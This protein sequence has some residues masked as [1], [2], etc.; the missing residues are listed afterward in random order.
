M[1]YMDDGGSALVADNDF[2]YFMGGTPLYSTY[3]EATYGTDSGSKG[4]INGQD[5]MAGVG[6]D[7]S[8]DPYPDNFTI[9]GANAVGIFA[10]ASSNT[11]LAGERIQRNAYKPSTSRGT[12]TT[13]AARRHRY[14]K[15]RCP[16]ARDEL[17]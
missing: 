6:T 5:I 13:R 11:G 3:F 17:A 7:I 2:G 10:N 16:A 12:S 9:N 15:D 1:A 4:V 14:H 8:S